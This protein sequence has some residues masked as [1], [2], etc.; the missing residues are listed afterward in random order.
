MMIQK[1]LGRISTLLCIA[2]FI[3]ACAIKEK[4]ENDPVALGLAEKNTHIPPNSLPSS[5]QEAL[6][7]K[8]QQS[9]TP[10]SSKRLDI[11]AQETPALAFFNS[12]SQASEINIIAD[13][14]L[15]GT[16]SLNMKD[17]TLLE[18]LKAVR[19]AYGFD[20]KPT[21]YG[22]RISARDLQ[23]RIFNL[24]YLNVK[25][26]GSSEIQVS[27]NSIKENISGASSDG[28]SESSSSTSE[29]AKVE[30]NTE[31]NFWVELEKI[32]EKMIEDEAGRKVFVDPIAGVVMVKAF[33]D[34]L[35]HIEEFLTTIQ[36]SLQRQ[37]VIE[38]K[39][40][41]V[42]LNEGYEEGIQWDTFGAGI[43]ADLDKPTF[44]DSGRPFATSLQGM[45]PTDVLGSK[46]RG[47]FS[48]NFNYKND[49]AGFI[50]LLKTQG[51]VRV[52]SSP[53]IS[54]VNNQKAV[55]KVGTDEFFV[56][57]V[58]TSTTSTTTTTN[59]TPEVTL[60]PFFSGIALDVTP[61]IGKDDEIILHVHPSVTEVV[62]QKRELSIFGQELS[63]PLAFS[64]VRETD[65]IV[66]AKNSQIVVM[67]GLL[68]SK[69]KDM[70]ARVPFLSDL[71]LIGTLFTQKRQQHQK[72]ELVILLKPMIMEQPEWNQALE[73]IKKRYPYWQS[74]RDQNDN[75]Y[76][77]ELN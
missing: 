74:G 3:V 28:G 15:K 5:I 11:Q 66:R 25:R 6:L 50:K 23:T 57:D 69:I 33:P 19:D 55:I 7:P 10:R 37:V 75:D 70:E 65:S 20:F 35:N 40:L 71:P 14:S 13:P 38:A 49:F 59:E 29:S 46:L 47:I 48:L 2:S 44:L 56:T 16:I 63:L 27:G 9:K 51:D 17:V 53:R 76:V 22:Y 30:T 42:Q 26:V 41:E 43:D 72:I 12:L 39:I 1:V 67:G 4:P 36:R 62:E 45:P 73:D 24:D 31:N 68:Q 52:L 34:E 77:F 61:Q 54:T 8:Y 18:I 21:A 64:T 60:T 32:L 58:S